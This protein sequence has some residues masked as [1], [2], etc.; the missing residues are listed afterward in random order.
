M[1]YPRQ[2]PRSK[3]RELAFTLAVSPQRVWLVSVALLSVY[4]L[5][6]DLHQRESERE[7]TLMFPPKTLLWYMNYL[8]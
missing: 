1:D 3:I 7:K 4:L 8:R 6:S 2:R 5:V